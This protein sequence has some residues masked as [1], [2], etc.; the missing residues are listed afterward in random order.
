MEPKDKNNESL[1]EDLLTS[2]SFDE[3][4]PAEKSFV[5]QHLTED[6][7]DSMRAVHRMASLP[8]VQS[9]MEPRHSTLTALLNHQQQFT[10]RPSARVL[11][12]VKLAA[13]IGFVTISTLMWYWGYSYGRSVP[14][15]RVVEHVTDTLL[16]QLPADTLFIEK[17]VYRKSEEAKAVTLVPP[18]PRTSPQGSSPNESVGISMKEK[19]DLN[20]LLVSGID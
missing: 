18:V 12:P 5:L 1:L 10:Q 3:L 6:E 19:E 14:Q 7:Y 8:D 15:A 16:V 11:L 4:S 2:K 9:D 20:S 13:A 17:V